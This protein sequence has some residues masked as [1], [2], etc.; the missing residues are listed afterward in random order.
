MATVNNIDDIIDDS[1]QV[2][3]EE[4]IKIIDFSVEDEPINGN[5]LTDDRFDSYTDFNTIQT[6]SITPPTGSTEIPTGSQQT[7]SIEP[8]TV[9]AP[10]PPSP[11]IK[12]NK[13][14]KK[15]NKSPEP[16][17]ENVPTEPAITNTNTPQEI[18]TLVDKIR[19]IDKLPT[20]IK[21]NAELIIGSPYNINT[22]GKLAHFFGQI[23]HESGGFV[24]LAESTDY[25]ADGLLKT[26]GSRINGNAEAKKIGRGGSIKPNQIGGWPDI[27]YGARKEGS[28]NGN[29][30]NTTEGYDF[31]GHGYIQITGKSK[32]VQ[33]DKQFPTE[34]ILE[35]PS[36]I[37]KSHKWA[38][39][40]SLVWWKGRNAVLRDDVNDAAIR[41]VTKA[42]N[43][44]TH[45]LVDRIKW[46]NFFYSKLK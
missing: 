37:S 12:K 4:V 22:P 42:V 19:A 34:D 2:T 43:G 27:V 29:K 23:Y 41:S 3:E 44:G 32:F 38:L 36:K 8:V 46:T 10:P 33:L 15:E 5:I 16:T 26:F 13:P 17:P 45:G 14:K 35:N 7:G 21:N 20:E 24:Y 1:P 9:A 31:R 39:I 40:A 18:K 25:S 6:G 11:V 30:F 28:R